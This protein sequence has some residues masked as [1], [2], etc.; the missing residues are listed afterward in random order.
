MRKKGG[1]NYINAS[2]LARR[3]GVGECAVRAALKVGR[4]TP[5]KV[6]NGKRF[7]LEDE[8]RE[9]WAQNTLPERRNG[10]SH[11]AG[12]GGG[13]KMTVTEAKAAREAASAKLIELKVKEKEERL[14]DAEEMARM[15]TAHVVDAKNLFLALP[16]EIRLRIPKLTADD[17][18]I[19]EDRIIGILD[20]L[21]SWDGKRK[22][23]NV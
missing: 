9:Q 3:L 22:K 6:E 1:E 13:V 15:W 17:I 10:I 8:A 4:L 19:I 20:N 7:F 5:A 14:V 11:V 23:T 16:V 18:A 21:S 12:S 2:E